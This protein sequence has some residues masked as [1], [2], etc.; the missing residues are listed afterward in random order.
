MNIKENLFKIKRVLHRNREEISRGISITLTVIL[1][2]VLGFAAFR[3]LQSDKQMELEA[4]LPKDESEIK[5]EKGWDYGESGFN[6]VA[7]NENYILAADYTTGEIRVTEKKS[8]YEWFS[9]PPDRKNDMIVAMRS[10]LN[11][12]MH[13]TFLNMETRAVVEQDN[14]AASI[15]KGGM[16]HELVENGVKFTFAFPAANVYIPVQYTLCED[17][18]KAEIL[19]S[20]IKRVGSN[21]FLVET[22]SFL[23]Y[24]GA[25]GL[26]DDGYLFVPDGSGALIN[27]NNGKQACSIYS[28]PVYG[29]N[30]TLEKTEEETVKERA[31]LP[32]FGGKTGDHAYIG[33]V[34]SGDSSSIIT[35]STSRKT[36]SYN[37][38]YSTA[39]FREY[40]LLIRNTS[41]DVGIQTRLLSHSD[42]L[43]NGKNYTVRYFFAEGEKANYTGMAELYRNYLEKTQQLKDSELADDKYLVLDLVGAVSIEKYVMGIKRPVVTAMTTYNQV[44]EIVKELKSKGIDNIIINYIGALNGGLDNKMYSKVTTESALGT[45]K[46]FRNMISYLEQEGVKLFL[47]TNPVD[48]YNNGNGYDK[49][50]D[51]VKSFF[52]KYAFQYKYELDSLKPTTDRWHLLHPELTEGFVNKFVDSAAKWNIKNISLARLGEVV[53]TDYADDVPSTTK[54]DTLEFWQAAMKSAS[55]KA[56][57][58]MMHG[59]NAYVAPYADVITDSSVGSS[60]FD[61]EDQAVPFYQLVFQNN[62]VLTTT[63]LNTTVDY[64]EGFLKALETGCSLKYNLV[65]GDVSELVG[66]KY[67]TMV[68]YSYEFWKDIIVEE[69]LEMNKATQAFAGE[70]IVRHEMLEPKVSLTEYESGT[71]IVNYND[72]SYTYQGTL[73]GPRD[74]LVISGGAK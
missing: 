47:E 17:G 26:D 67:N 59:G 34:V 50:R 56:D 27:Y 63:P 13:V 22:I 25:A 40:S 1:V 70:K 10:R 11:S 14:Y 74:Y 30:P 58:F 44:V 32:V 19:T 16:S 12:Q 62:T 65:Y 64:T 20:E 42:E 37:A 57:Y 68:S 48:I 71:L 41:V 45:K 18:F 21:A 66:T 72:E 52:N 43:F 8:G 4:S 28:A 3:I 46:E 55:E 29:R 39:V 53:Y 7:E 31:S 2:I 51:S 15:K 49:N 24:F 36:S 23:P 5:I 54:M 6:T 9:N 33:V 38:A 61:M 73:V 60:D 35:G 69:Y